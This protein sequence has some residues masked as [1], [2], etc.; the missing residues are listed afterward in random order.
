MAYD[1][2][3]TFNYGEDLENL[4]EFAVVMRD[5][6]EPVSRIDGKYQVVDNDL[7]EIGLLAQ[8]AEVDEEGQ[9]R[10]RYTATLRGR[11]EVLQGIKQVQWNVPTLQGTTSITTDAQGVHRVTAMT[12]DPQVEVEAVIDLGR[13][14]P[15]SLKKDAW[16]P[17]G[18]AA[19]SLRMQRH[20]AFHGRDEDKTS[21]FRTSFLPKMSDAD[22]RALESI[23]YE[24][25]ST[26]ADA[27]PT[28]YLHDGG[29]PPT[30]TPEHP[31]Y[32]Y[33]VVSEPLQGVA[34]LTFRDGTTYALTLPEE[35]F[36]VS[37][38]YHPYVEADWRL[39]GRDGD[40]NWYYY[41]LEVFYPESWT[42]ELQSCSITLGR[43]TAFQVESARLSEGPEAKRFLFHGYTDVPFRAGAT[44]TFLEDHPEF[45]FTYPAPSA[46]MI[47]VDTDASW[48]D[49]FPD[50]TQLFNDGDALTLRSESQYLGETSEGPV[51]RYDL[52]L[53]GTANVWAI[54]G[55][56]WTIPSGTI[57]CHR[58]EADDPGPETGYAISLVTGP[59]P[60]EVSAHL[61]DAYDGEHDLRKTVV[62]HARR[63][64]ALF[65]DMAEYDVASLL[66]EAPD[67][68]LSRV[69]LF[70]MA[71]DLAGVRKVEAMVPRAWGGALRMSLADLEPLQLWDPN[72]GEL[73]TLRDQE[74][75][76]FL[77]HEDHS[78]T[79]L[80]SKPHVRGPH[81]VA[82]RLQLE[83]RDAALGF[84]H[85]IHEWRVSAALKGDFLV[86]EQIEEVTWTVTDARGQSVPFEP[87][88]DAGSRTP[89]ITWLTPH[90]GQVQAQVRFHDSSGRAPM[91]L[92]APVYLVAE[93]R[94]QRPTA[95]WHQVLVEPVSSTDAAMMEMGYEEESASYEV[96]LAASPRF[97][98]D[99]K[100]V[101]W[102]VRDLE[103]EEAL[104]E[105]APPPKVVVH[106]MADFADGIPRHTVHGY[107]GYAVPVQAT[108]VAADGTTLVLEEVLAGNQEE[109]MAFYRNQKR[110]EWETRYWGEQDGKPL[111]LLF[112]RIG[113]SLQ[114][115]LSIS[116][117]YGFRDPVQVAGGGPAITHGMPHG[118]REFLIEGANQLNHVVIEFREDGYASTEKDEKNLKRLEVLAADVIT[119]SS[120]AHI[121]ASSGLHHLHLQMA[122]MDLLATGHVD[123]TVIQA[124]ETTTYRISNR[125]GTLSDAFELRLSGPRPT[126]VQAQR[127]VGTGALGEALKL[128]L[129]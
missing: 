51:Y 104:G 49:L 81:P 23:T 22:W 60:F 47:A 80:R 64:N 37:T 82:P 111:S 96:S 16:V 107:W 36:T 6:R 117:T 70:G 121:E 2:L 115:P 48:K 77:H 78:I 3:D 74:I 52:F 100:E 93:A 15:L 99:W 127:Y 8:Y 92:T 119:E 98:K 38:A 53:E 63:S 87:P 109:V 21:R 34:H 46:A 12:L 45:G 102:R 128:D 108:L 41:Q 85:G 7:L 39:E 75:T 31:A 32:L 95:Q 79:T 86:R 91:Q 54:S 30:W 116:A 71:E 58:D 72:L 112:C 105:D 69:R 56:D 13:S 106:A 24:I 62:P 19:R 68:N 55:V 26:D 113:A 11:Q 50:P 29:L 76:F 20:V 123:Y 118:S 27:S 88:T 89:R 44:L 101:H 61:L 43:N 73:E 66:Q 28:P 67:R 97:L 124:G 65:L 17:S 90:E 57:H 1:L 126:S 5:R 18:Q 4:L 59:E 94:N 122:E 33:R 125:I 114:D 35:D 103:S 9:Q 120:I 83:V 129:Q 14:E 110:V 84:A 40:R 25:S 10:F 42:E